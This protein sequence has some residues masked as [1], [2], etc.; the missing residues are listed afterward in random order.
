MNERHYQLFPEV[1]RYWDYYASD[2]G[3]EVTAAVTAALDGHFGAGQRAIVAGA[4]LR[5]FGVL[6][7]GEMLQTEPP[8]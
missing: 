8:Q 3:K 5:G 7:P 2:A 1:Y 4:V 6:S